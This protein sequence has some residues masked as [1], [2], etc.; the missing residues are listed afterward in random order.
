MISN[1]RPADYYPSLDGLRFVCCSVVVLG[2]SIL[3]NPRWNN[4]A[5]SISRMGVDI[6]FSLSGF[7]ITSLLLREKVE[8]GSVSLFNFYMRR[9]LRI[10][11]AYY[12]ALFIKLALLGFLGQRYLQMF[13]S[14]ATSL[15][16]GKLSLTYLLFLG[17]WIIY[18]VPTTMAL[19]WSICV[20]E[21][22]YILF[23][24]MFVFSR[25]KYPVLL[26]A[27]I[28]L[29]VCIGSR[30]L[31]A[32]RLPEHTVYVNTITHGDNLLIGA[33]LAQLFNSFPSAIAKIVA[34][35]GF[36]IE[37]VLFFGMPVYYAVLSSLALGPAG[38]TLTYFL[39]AI[40]S[41]ALVMVIGFGN[42]PIARILGWKLP[43]YLGGLTYA[44]YM[45][46]E[47]AVGASWVVVRKLVHDPYSASL[48]RWV[49]AVPLTFL[50]AYL[51]R[52]TFEARILKLKNR[53]AP[54]VRSIERLKA[55]AG[56]P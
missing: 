49:V 35:G 15:P 18:T 45:F 42:G 38:V 17:N 4:P 28:G 13:G 36:L 30:A 54:A 2:H 16:L 24:V 31:L 5:L 26:P 8:Y 27:G 3:G 29:V 22:F 7:L 41:T 11:P 46:H 20:E 1:S 39:S 23:P 10:W 19:M 37:A 9:T 44:G 33:L 51:V 50:L 52:I 21:Q 14:D 43:V 47:F 53:F 48:L 32:A 12:T 25:R 55:A 34:K 6:F 56:T 40:L